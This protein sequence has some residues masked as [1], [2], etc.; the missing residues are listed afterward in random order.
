[1]LAHQAGWNPSYPSAVAVYSTS[2]RR[3]AEGGARWETALARLDE[4]WIDRA[5]IWS[6]RY[7][8]ART[9]A[10]GWF[11]PRTPPGGPARFC[12]PSRGRLECR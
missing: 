12:L 3:L 6:G 9:G 5:A 8:L 4:G 2:E 10:R 11:L 7:A 1:M